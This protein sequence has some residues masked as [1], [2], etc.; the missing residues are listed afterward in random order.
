MKSNNTAATQLHRAVLTPVDNWKCKARRSSSVHVGFSSA[1][2]PAV[3][4]PMY[5]VMGCQAERLR[6]IRY[7]RII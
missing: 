2:I 7:N 3:P 4:V 5:S 6:Y 1:V